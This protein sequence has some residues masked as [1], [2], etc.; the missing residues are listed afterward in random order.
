MDEVTGTAELMKAAQDHSDVGDH[1][2]AERLFAQAAER[3]SAVA[4]FN[5]GNAL[6]SLGRLDEAAAALREAMEAGEADAPLNLGML[7]HEQGDLE[8][9]MSAYKAAV[10][11]GDPRGTAFLGDALWEFDRPEGEKLLRSS[12][13]QR[14]AHAAAQLVFRLR[15][16]GSS[17]DLE[18]LL[19]LAASVN[20]DAAVDLGRL[21]RRKGR[22]AEAEALLR[23]EVAKGSTDAMIAL[24]LLLE[25]DR[26]DIKAA[27]VVL[28]AATDANE[29]HAWNNLGLLLEQQG[30]YIEAVD[31][32]SHGVSGGDPVARRNLKR[33]RSTYR[34]QINRHWRQKR[35]R[36]G[37]E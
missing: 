20:D 36:A 7:L 34:R 30:Q 1:D 22:T 18:D 14:D 26:G 3:G 9:A 12:V 15:E 27:E 29:L 25:E 10:D 21:V 28:R 37:A 23:A 16:A 32:F 17:E 35:R 19:R 13:Q 8:G 33:V 31:A 6:W 2:R 24:A 5:Q 11:A 4:R